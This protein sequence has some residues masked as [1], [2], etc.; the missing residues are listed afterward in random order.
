MGPL[1]DFDSITRVP[2]SIGNFDPVLG[3]SPPEC[4]NLAP[5]LL[6]ALCSVLAEH[7]RT[8][9]LC[10]FCLWEGYGWLND[11]GAGWTF[12]PKDHVPDEPIQSPNPPHAPER[13]VS[14]W[15]R[16][17]RVH[18]PWRDYLLLRGPLDAARELGWTLSPGHF[19]GQSPNLFWPQ[20]HAWCVASEIDF[21]CTLVAGSEGLADAIT[22]DSRLEAWRFSPSDSLP[23]PGD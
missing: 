6:A 21:F 10:W 18:L 23:G 17:A 14:E 13:I 19:I 1:A 11:G 8:P 20:D 7:T 16:A 2:L 12:Y 22:S 5:D 4:G 3:I 15:L 9:E